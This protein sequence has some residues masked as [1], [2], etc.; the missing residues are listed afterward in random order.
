[1]IFESQNRTVIQLNFLHLEGTD[2][3]L[4]V[5]EKNVFQFLE[6]VHRGENMTDDI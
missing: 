3:T 2:N 4:A 5:Y 6:H 1:M